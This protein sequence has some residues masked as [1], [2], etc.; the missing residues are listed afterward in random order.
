MNDLTKK[1]LESVNSGA[2]KLPRNLEFMLDREANNWANKDKQLLQDMKAKEEAEL[3]TIIAEKKTRIS[4]LEIKIK[5]AEIEVK[6]IEKPNP[7]KIV[8]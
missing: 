8:K 7:V 2:N 5:E 1:Y 4:E 3:E 6:P